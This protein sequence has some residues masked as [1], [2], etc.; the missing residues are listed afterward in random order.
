[1]ALESAL[2]IHLILNL[3]CITKETSFIISVYNPWGFLAFC[4]FF[5]KSL[6]FFSPL[7]FDLLFYRLSKSCFGKAGR[8]NPAP[9]TVN[10]YRPRHSHHNDTIYLPPFPS[11][12]HPRQWLQDCHY[13][14]TPTPPTFTLPIPG[15]SYRIYTLKMNFSQHYIQTML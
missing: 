15:I 6:I 10:G 5:F 7:Y 9:R 3:L 1:M 2:P 14:S 4:F 8:F 11:P 13:T 12:C